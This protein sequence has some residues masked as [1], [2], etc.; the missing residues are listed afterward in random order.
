MSRSR[1]LFFI[2]STALVLPILA[3]SLLGAASQDQAADGGDSLYKYLSVFTESLGLV[4]QTYV[5]KTDPNT[6]MNAALDGIT[7]ALDPLAVYVP[8]DSVKG[9]VEARRVGAARSGIFPLR[10]RGMI[11]VLAV[12]PGSPADEAGVQSGDLI[13]EIQ[14]R[15][16][17]VLPVWQL[18][19]ILAGPPGT[20]VKLKL[21]RFA[22]NVEATVKLEDFR[23]PRPE[24]EDHDGTPVLTIPVFDDQTLSEVSSILGSLGDRDKLV[25]DLRDTAGGDSQVAYRVGGLFASGELGR[26]QDHDKPLESYTGQGG[27][28]KG[29]IVVLTDRSTLGPAELLAAILRQ[30][31]GAELVG[32][33]TFGYGGRQSKVDLSD[34][35][36]LFLADA[37]YTGPDFKPLD[38][39]LQP[40]ER[41]SAR[42]RTFSETEQGN[43]TKDAKP[44]DLILEK[45]IERL[46]KPPEPAKKAA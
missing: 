15:E 43:E 4:Q 33:H 6:L 26:L 27:A 19:E 29:R 41:V 46:Q 34:G 24:L 30:K 7:D 36:A 23:A 21:V 5:E 28:W 8:H 18:E 40:D 45:G 11:Y 13:S 32:E 31:A 44:P 1:F 17:R 37:F 39:P 14:G 12:T 22:E 2:A 16:T 10:E 42:D 9:Y 20:E 38:E 35:G 3:G 25:V